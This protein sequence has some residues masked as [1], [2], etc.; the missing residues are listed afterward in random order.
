MLDILLV[1]IRMDRGFREDLNSIHL[2]LYRYFRDV[3]VQNCA[4]I[5]K[6]I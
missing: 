1:E 6:Y 4:M 3:R 2:L 5:N